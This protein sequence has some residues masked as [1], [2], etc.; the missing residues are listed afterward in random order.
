M[1]ENAIKSNAG[2]VASQKGINPALAQ[3]LAPQN[4]A[5]MQQQAAGQGSM[6]G[7]QRQLS[8]AAYALREISTGGSMA[9]QSNQQQSTLQ[10][11]LASYNNANVN[12]QS[13]LNS[14]NAGVAGQ[15]AATWPAVSQEA[16]SAVSAA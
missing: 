5:N 2:M 7:M 6:Q 16:R 10:H 13:N 11:A 9:G 12:M 14:V 3:S 8:S 4:S 15:N 1:N